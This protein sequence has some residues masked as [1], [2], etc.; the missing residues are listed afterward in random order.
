VSS[1]VGLAAERRMVVLIR[2]WI[3][4]DQVRGKAEIEEP[5][6]ENEELVCRRRKRRTGRERGEEGRA[7]SSTLQLPNDPPLRR[8]RPC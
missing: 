7:S 6:A 4:Q 8:Q 2:R 1:Q 5:T 3:D